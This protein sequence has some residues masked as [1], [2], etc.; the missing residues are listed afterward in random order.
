MATCEDCYHPVNGWVVNRTVRAST[1]PHLYIA[2]S[3]G[4]QYRRMWSERGEL[5]E[6]P[7]RANG[8]MGI[9]QM[10]AFMG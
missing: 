8:S 9:F 2:S 6:F 3:T 7:T 1:N 10:G 5:T 4:G